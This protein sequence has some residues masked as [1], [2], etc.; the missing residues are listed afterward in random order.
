MSPGLA[1]AIGQEV[2]LS[3]AAE[4]PLPYGPRLTRLL[5]AVHR[6]FLAVNR[7]AAVPLLR[8][9]LA[10]LFATPLT[11]SLMVLRTRGRQSGLWRNA[12]LGYVILDGSVYC[13]AGF[14][15]STQWFRNVETDPRVE[16]LLPAS[17][18]AGLAQEVTDPQEWGRAMRAL[19]VSMGIVG[20]A[21]VGDVRRASDEGLRTLAGGIPLVRV[22]VTGLAAGPFDPGG[23]GWVLPS[24]ISVA[25]LTCWVRRRLRHGRRR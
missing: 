20:R 16:V 21:T 3:T 6:A 2:A 23:L 11:G 18:V 9:G 10:P 4:D 14:G 15:R 1:T 25:W 5:P 24:A 8:S 7:Y 19:L 22:R 17:A 13:C 12:P